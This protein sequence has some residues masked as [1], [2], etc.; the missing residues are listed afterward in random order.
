MF[1]VGKS[2]EQSD[3]S[4]ASVPFCPLPADVRGAVAAGFR[5]GRSPDVMATTAG[6]PVVEPPHQGSAPWPSSDP[7]DLRVPIAFLGSRIA[8]GSLPDGMGLD[9]IA[10]TLAQ[11]IG[12]ARAHP[13]V[14]AGTAVALGDGASE[15]ARD[16]AGRGDR[17]GRRGDAGP[18]KRMAPPHRAHD[19][20]GWGGHAARHDGL[21]SARPHRD[22]HDD[23]HGRIAVPARD[24][25]IT[26]PGRA[27]RGR[28]PLDRRRADLRDL[29]P[30]GRSPS[31]VRG[32]LARGHRR[33]PTDGPRPGG[34][35]VVPGRAAERRRDGGE[36]SAARR[37]QAAPSRLR[38][39]RRRARRDGR[40]AARPHRARGHAHG[41]HRLRRTGPGA[42]GP[43]RD[44]RNRRRGK[45]RGDAL[46]PDR[47]ARGRGARRPG[48]ERL[49]GGRVLPEHEGARRRR[50]HGRRGRRDR[51]AR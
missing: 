12:Y 13:E 36:R 43:D 49:R 34:E 27:R 23:G 40:G 16:T 17:V 6:L 11:V 50:S 29:H 2:C 33:G 46:G 25:G 14:R 9:Q 21:P 28:G 44:R 51:C 38:I 10:P 48:G 3:A 5:A 42:R 19:P 47:A 39:A 35:R 24:H 20:R 30:R 31:L 8:R 37:P 18:R 45:G 22:A 41:R 7:P 26:D 15:R 1:C 32:P 4:T